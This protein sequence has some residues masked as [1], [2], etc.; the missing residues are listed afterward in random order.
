METAACPTIKDGI[1]G[2]YAAFRVSSTYSGPTVRIRRGN[3]GGT[4]D[5]YANKQ[6]SLGTTVDGGGTALSQWLSGAQGYVVIWYDQSG[7][8]RHATQY[9]STS[10]PIFNHLNKFIDF[11]AQ[12]GTAYLNLPDGTVPQRIQY[13]VTVKHNNIND[14]G[15]GWLSGG[16][17]FVQRGS[18]GFRRI[19]SSYTNWWWSND[20][21]CDGYAPGNTVTFQYDGSARE[22]YVNGALKST[23]YSSN[24]NGAVGSEYIAYVPNW[25]FMNGE[26][27]FLHIFASSLDNAS[28]TLVETGFL[29]GCP[30]GNSPHFYPH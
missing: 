27:Y 29:E 14:V 1:R 11:T 10:Q 4:L 24:W 21:T 19:G 9:T 25:G 22:A 30:T 16:M 20:I 6:G 23:L 13:T 2:S 3:D 12:S 7:Q 28:R 15:G 26:L 17:T 8:G 18:N 5:F